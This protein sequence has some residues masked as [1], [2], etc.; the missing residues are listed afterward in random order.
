[1]QLDEQRRVENFAIVCP[2]KDIEDP[3][4]LAFLAALIQDHDHLREKLL[5]EPD[6]RKRVEKLDAMR[7]HLHFTASSLSVYEAAEIARQCGVQPI[8]EEQKKAERSRIW[9][10][11]SR[12]HEVRG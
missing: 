2:L 10:P 7:P 11:Q 3:D 6:R 9:M 1:M 4:M 5:T 8:Y 12:I